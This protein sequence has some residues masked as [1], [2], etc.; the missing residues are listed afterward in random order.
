M[1]I[2]KKETSIVFRPSKA[3]V[4]RVQVTIGGLGQLAKD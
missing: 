3:A 4:I 1:H 2:C